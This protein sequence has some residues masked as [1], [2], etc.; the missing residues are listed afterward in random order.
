MQILCG[1]VTS[2]YSCLRD[3]CDCGGDVC[4]WGAGGQRWSPAVRTV[5]SAGRTFSVPYLPVSSAPVKGQKR[6][7]ADVAATRLGRVVRGERERV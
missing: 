2:V 3:V 7:V 1:P 6:V 4:L 5:A